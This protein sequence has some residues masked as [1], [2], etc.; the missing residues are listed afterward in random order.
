MAIVTSTIKNSFFHLAELLYPPQCPACNYPITRTDDTLCPKCWQQ[1]REAILTPAC[2]TCG[3]PTSQYEIYNNKCH[4]CQDNQ[5]NIDF[6]IRVGDYQSSLKNLVLS[7]KYHHQSRLDK[8]L[9]KLA[10]D[11]A[12]SRPETRS[13]DYL[14]PIPLHWRRRFTRGYNQSEILAEQIAKHLKLSNISIPVRHDLIRT[15]NTPPQTTLPAGK[16]KN[17]LKNA[18][19][20]RPDAPFKNKNICLVD[21]VTTTGTTLNTAAKTLKRYGAKSV[22]A[23]VIIVPEYF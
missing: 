5:T 20:I 3:K 15:R 1:L 2:P 21:D 6:I 10:A 12:L 23:I 13:L 17:N 19:A 16:R 9:G 7:F 14:V 4:R 18:F 11:T 22:S 8:F